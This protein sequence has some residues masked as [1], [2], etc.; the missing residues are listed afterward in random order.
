M[1]YLWLVFHEE[2]KRN[3]LI[4]QAGLTTMALITAGTTSTDGL[5]ALAMK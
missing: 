3:S 4:R 5:I 2:K 1:R